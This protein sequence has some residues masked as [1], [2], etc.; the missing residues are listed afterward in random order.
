MFMGK[1]NN[2]KMK[3]KDLQFN[4]C[5]LEYNRAINY[6]G[7]NYFN[8][9]VTVQ[10]NKDKYIL[11]VGSSDR[12]YSLIEGHMLYIVGENIGL[13]YISCIEIDMK[14]KQVL[15]DVFIENVDENEFTEDIFDLDTEEQI[16]ILSEWFN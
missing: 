15:N 14:N 16:K 4:Y 11:G 3:I 8:P 12:L 10:I 5:D 7:T 9:P 6:D 13:S 1:L 2:L